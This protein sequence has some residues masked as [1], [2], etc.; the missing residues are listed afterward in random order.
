MHKIVLAAAVCGLLVTGCTTTERHIAGTT[1]VGA[2]TGAIIGG[3]AN[4]GSGALVGAAIG[5][6]TGAV[7]G[8]ATAPRRKCWSRDYWGNPIKVRC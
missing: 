2:G 8:S 3:I 5:A 1:A 4:G 6:G 7:V